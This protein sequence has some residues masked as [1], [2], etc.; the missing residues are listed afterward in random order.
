MGAGDDLWPR[1]ADDW[2]EPLDLIEA[3][4][5]PRNRL[6]PALAIAAAVAWAAAATWLAWGELATASSID[7]LVFVA[8]LCVPPLLGG[9]V[10]LLVQRT[11]RA[12]ARRFGLT[13]RAMRAEAAALE[14]RVAGL[15]RTLASQREQL[16]QQLDAGTVAAGRLEAIGRVVAD[17]IARADEH[18]H[19]LAEAGE[20][21]RA[22]VGDLIAA[23]PHARSEA[24]EIGR[25][26]DQAGLTAAAQIAGLDAQ[27]VA[28]DA[29]AQDADEHAT[30]TAGRLADHIA[31]MDAAGES[32]G[33]RLDQATAVAAEALDAMLARTERA[34]ARTSDTLAA[35]GEA[36]HATLA[37]QAEALDHAARTNAEA[38]AAR[39]AAIDDAVA[40]VGVAIEAQAG[41]GARFT[42]DFRDGIGA[43]ERRLE[44]LHVQGVERAQTLAA[45]IS[46]LGG[47]A[48]AMTEALRAG[49]AMAT[50]A[51]GTT[52]TLL[53][54]LDSAAREI[55]ETLPDALGRL[56]ARI[57]E[58]RHVVAA[59]KPELLA[60]VTAAES[61]HDAIEAIAG[62]LAEQRR[63]VDQLSATLIETLTAGRTKADAVGRMVEETIGRTQSFAEEAAPRLLD[64]L[65]RVRDTAQ[66]AADRA[67]ETLAAVIPEAADA[68]EHAAADAMRRATSDTVQRQVE[69]LGDASRAAVDAATR[70]TEKL[71]GHVH[72][73]G[74]QTALVEARLEEAQAQRESADSDSLARRVSLLIES[75]NSAAIDVTRLLAPEVTDSAWAAYL[76]GD[77]GV[78][79]RRAVR[80]LDNTQARD[81]GRLYDDDARFR[82]QVNR[83]IHDFESMLRQVLAQREGAP[84]GVTL[85]SSDMGKLYVALAQAIERLR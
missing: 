3:E 55:D 4:D 37:A 48:D 28:L 81:I 22:T 83:Y 64:A 15:S 11:S 63:T 8:A 12:E 70:A 74:E 47:S 84:L 85:L 25:R 34:V 33:A 31:R 10:W 53:I 19:A 58:S 80:L 21:A 23:M 26:I 13:A 44:A 57:L 68:L 66:V 50:G 62:V 39:I 82:E 42:D 36:A 59:A 65:L 1:A 16:T 72:A 71:A 7:R 56:D 67:R 2:R 27:L 73:I 9:V 69:A 54:A 76:K 32:A 75:L 61:T 78:F 30:A 24:E 46:A 20:R 29:R 60:L 79:T 18:A 52:E 38:I 6:P 45:S 77:R 43:V 40:A 41:A 49:E 14:S 17:E 51:I 5:P 35:Q